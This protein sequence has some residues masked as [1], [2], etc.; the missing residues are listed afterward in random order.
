MGCSRH[1]GNTLSEH[2]RWFYEKY[3]GI[4]V[5]SINIPTESEWLNSESVLMADKSSMP[6]I[7]VEYGGSRVAGYVQEDLIVD[8]DPYYEQY[9]EWKE[10]FNSIGD[11]MT[12]YTA[13]G[14][15]EHMV[16]LGLHMK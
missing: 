6:N 13:Y 16:Y 1:N 12:D 15:E 5:E 3:P 9:P 14:V 4:K 11:G 10:R 8:M 7:I 2:R